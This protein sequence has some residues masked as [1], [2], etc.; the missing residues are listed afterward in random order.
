[1][2]GINITEEIIELHNRKRIEKNQ[3]QK[4]AL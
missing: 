2:K 1:M 3:D 4:L